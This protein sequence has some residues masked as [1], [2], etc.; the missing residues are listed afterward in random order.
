MSLKIIKAQTETKI[1]KASAHRKLFRTI[2][3]TTK[4]QSHTYTT[5]TNSK[6]VKQIERGK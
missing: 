5:K 6:P 1:K 2:C 4:Q 3:F